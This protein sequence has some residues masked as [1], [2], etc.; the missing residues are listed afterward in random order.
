V[1][2]EKGKGLVWGWKFY[3]DRGDEYFIPL[4]GFLELGFPCF[5]SDPSFASAILKENRPLSVR[6]VA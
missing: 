2:F 3:W 6:S 4:I 5:T 1:Q